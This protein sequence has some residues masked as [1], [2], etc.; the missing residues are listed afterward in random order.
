MKKL[1]QGIVEYLHNKGIIDWFKNRA[2][3]STEFQGEVI[4]V[5]QQ[6]AS[7]DRWIS[8]NADFEELAE[9]FLGSNIGTCSV[10]KLDSVLN[11]A[12]ILLALFA[13]R[14]RFS[15]DKTHSIRIPKNEI[16]ELGLQLIQTNGE[17]DLEDV[18]KLHWDI[19]GTKDKFERL[20][21]LISQRSK[22]C[23]DRFRILEQKQVREGLKNFITLPDA[24]DSLRKKCLKATKSN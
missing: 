4:F 16:E 24:S 9:K 19:V 20:A 21:E 5:R 2:Q 3:K 10:Y 17:T 12:K 22:S 7:T 8:D 18:N 14:P 23:E 15:L 6:S 11:E 13:T 1:I